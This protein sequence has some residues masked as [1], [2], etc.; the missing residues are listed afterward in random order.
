[1]YYLNHFAV[2]L[3]LIHVVSQL[4]KQTNTVV[5]V[6]FPASGSCMF[7]PQS[8]LDINNWCDVRHPCQPPLLFPPFLFWRCEQK[9]VIPERKR[10]H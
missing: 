7:C 5:R 10:G 1:M 3:K 2:H 4:K 8:Q 6:V 9:T